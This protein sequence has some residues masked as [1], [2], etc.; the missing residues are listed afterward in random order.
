LN[1]MIASPELRASF[2]QEARRRFLSARLSAQMEE[3][4]RAV[5]LDVL[6]TRGT[7]VALSI[8]ANGELRYVEP[9]KP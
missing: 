7:K 9:S 1:S 4:T 5:Y 2:G 8:P 3:E 6:R